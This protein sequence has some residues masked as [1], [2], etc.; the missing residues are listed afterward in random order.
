MLSFWMKLGTHPPFPIRRH[1]HTTLLRLL[2][3]VGVDLAPQDLCVSVKGKS[4]DGALTP[5]VHG[6]F[7]ALNA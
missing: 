4:I 2:R 3:R 6:E 7:A 5:P 1:V